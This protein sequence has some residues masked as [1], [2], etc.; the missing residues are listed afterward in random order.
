[1]STY[2]AMIPLFAAHHGKHVKPVSIAHFQH[3]GLAVSPLLY[4]MAVA[5]IAV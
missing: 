4:A 5:A 2:A 3:S 1:V